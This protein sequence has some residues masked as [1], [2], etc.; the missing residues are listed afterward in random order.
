MKPVQVDR[1]ATRHGQPRHGWPKSKLTAPEDFRQMRQTG[2]FD[3]ARCAGLLG[4]SERA[5]RYWE[6]GKRRIPYA[7]FRLLRVLVGRGLPW[8]GWEEFMIIG[9]RLIS[10]EGHEFSR[11]D[12]AYISLTFRQAE[13][14]RSTYAALS[15]LQRSVALQSEN[16]QKGGSACNLL[17][18]GQ[19]Q[20]SNALPG[21]L[22]ASGGPSRL[23]AR[24]HKTP[25]F[26]VPRFI[27]SAR[28]ARLPSPAPP[29][30]V[31]TSPRM[32]GGRLDALSRFQGPIAWQE[33]G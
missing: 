26:G 33:R 27:A 20:G 5:V 23:V 28:S 9:N 31:P 6:A 14:F 8:R 13:A 19:A 1:T 18:K 22:P 2:G 21:T 30:R 15:E 16:E 32:P 3:R 29:A 24:T 7:A 25:P 4:V 11:G 10:P 12:L 17:K